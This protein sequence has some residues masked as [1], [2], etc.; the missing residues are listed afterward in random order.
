M[1]T[2]LLTYA[3]A[4]ATLIGS[5]L[6]WAAGLFPDAGVK[7]LYMTH[8]AECHDRR[9]RGGAE[10]PSLKQNELIIKMDDKTLIKIISDGVLKK[11]KRHPVSEFAGEMKGFSDT[12]SKEEIRSLTDLMRQW[13]R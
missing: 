12:L 5:S 10:G 8:C 11:E 9:G 6:V 1:P 4:C 13:N 3:I 7:L 2:K